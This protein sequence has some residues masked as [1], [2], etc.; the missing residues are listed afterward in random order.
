MDDNFVSDV[1][2]EVKRALTTLSVAVEVDEDTRIVRTHQHEHSLTAVEKK[3]RPPSLE[4][5]K[6]LRLFEHEEERIKEVGFKHL[7]L[8]LYRNQLLHWFVPEAMLALSLSH[9]GDCD[10]HLGE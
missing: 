9:S 8:S 4:Q 3:E 10:T 7:L 6:T 2:G 5:L 1:A